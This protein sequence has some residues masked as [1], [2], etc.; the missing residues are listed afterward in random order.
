MDRWYVVHSHA[1][2]EANA[3][4]HLQ[5]QG[6]R[7]Y[8]PRWRKRRSHARRV[9]WVPAPLFPRYLFVRFD[10]E[11]TRWRAIQSTVGVSH[12]ISVGGSLPAPVP[13]GI[14]EAIHSREAENGLIEIVPS[15]RKGEPVVIGEGP[16][17]DQI[18][19]FES[20]DD[21]ARVTVLLGL[22]GREIKVRIPAYAVRAVA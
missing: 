21:A 5:R 22:L 3:A 16:F 19:L 11:R 18:G 20:L 1:G 12:L 2:A 8:L 13:E 6:Y 4:R 10:I 7:V 14:V 17:L 15:F 9:E